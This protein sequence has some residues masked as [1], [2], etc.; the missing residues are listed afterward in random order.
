[1][2]QSRQA[3]AFLAACIIL[4][5]LPLGAL[6]ESSY[7]SSGDWYSWASYSNY[8][9]WYTWASYSNYTPNTPWY[10]WATW[11]S[12]PGYTETP[13]L[14]GVVASSSSY[15]ANNTWYWWSP[16]EELEKLGGAGALA[17]NPANLGALSEIEKDYADTSSINCGIVD[18]M[19][20]NAT[21]VNTAYNIPSGGEG[22][23]GF[24]PPTS[25]PSLD[26]AR[27][28]VSGMVAVNIEL[29]ID[30]AL[31]HDSL[32]VPIAIQIDKP[33]G[34]S[35]NFEI[36]HYR[37][38]IDRAPVSLPYT[39]IAGKIN[40]IADHFSTFV[41]VD[42][43]DSD[44]G[45]GASASR[46]RERGPAPIVPMLYDVF[47]T[48]DSF[49]FKAVIANGPG[50]MAGATV[51]VTLNERYSTTVTIGQDGVGLGTISAPGFSGGTAV[52]T[53]KVNGAGV[54]V[55]Q[56]MAVYSDGR[57]VRK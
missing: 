5:L 7:N 3:A 47:K 49:S 23:L 20:F 45:S 28:S 34:L 26:P 2:R 39:F 8:T 52:F 40:F 21:A 32:T 22:L 11:T 48:G 37:N 50:N 33:E 36:L 56:Q 44:S 41:F 14:Q 1:M 31:I 55:N 12:A 15:S 16:V 17:A 29:Y 10:D 25:L 54:S 6:A 9:P 46:A 27:Y 38:G 57:V 24:I 4:A 13:G 51:S 53:V 43:T 42:A 18:Q 19:S 30:G 35:D